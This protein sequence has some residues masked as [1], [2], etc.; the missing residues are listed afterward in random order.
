MQSQRPGNGILL[1]SQW[2]IDV[3]QRQSGI[4]AIASRFASVSDALRISFSL[5]AVSGPFL[6]YSVHNRRGYAAGCGKGRQMIAHSSFSRLPVLWDQTKPARCISS[7][8][9]SACRT[10]AL[11]RKLQHQGN[12]ASSPRKQ[13]PLLPVS[14]ARSLSSQRETWKQRQD[15]M[16]RTDRQR[17]MVTSLLCNLL[18]SPDSIWCIYHALYPCTLYTL[19]PVDQPSSTTLRT[20][21]V[22]PLQSFDHLQIVVFAGAILALK[23][24]FSDKK[25]AVQASPSTFPEDYCCRESPSSIVELNARQPAI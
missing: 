24:L 3:K 20:G 23:R 11:L 10:I 2:Q 4:R 25:C 9:Y 12:L 6:P 1:R 17:A 5:I 7:S 21:R 19:Q 8:E 22:G 15:Q 14:S 13:D 16:L 18:R